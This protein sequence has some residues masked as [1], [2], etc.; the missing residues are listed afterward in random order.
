MKELNK[1]LLKNLMRIAQSHHVAIILVGYMNKGKVSKSSYR[2][3]GSIDISTAALSVLICGE[4]KNEDGVR[5]I[6]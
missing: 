2:N 6:I 1:P 4:L 3:L 5:A